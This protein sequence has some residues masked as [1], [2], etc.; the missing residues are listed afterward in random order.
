MELKLYCNQRFT[1]KEKPKNTQSR[2]CVPPT[3]YKEPFQISSEQAYWYQS[4]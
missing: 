2:C 3:K 1:L 4:T